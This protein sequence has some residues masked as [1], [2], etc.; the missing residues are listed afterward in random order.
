M[1]LNTFLRFL[2]IIIL[3]LNVLYL[4]TMRRLGV[5]LYVDIVLGCIELFRRFVW[6]IFRLEN[7]Q[8]SNIDQYRVTMD[9]PL[10]FETHTVLV[11]K[12]NHLEKFEEFRFKLCPCWKREDDPFLDYETSIEDFISRTTKKILRRK[13]ENQNNAS[14]RLERIENPESVLLD[15]D[16][17]R[18]SVDLIRHE[19]ELKFDSIGD[20]NQRIPLS[21]VRSV[22]RRPSIVEPQDQVSLPEKKDQ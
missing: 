19:S 5:T 4:D 17:L 12:E 18:H 8:L 21:P 11:E 10:P 3:I 6:N 15:E 14:M 13:P 20:T 9:V 22:S 7:E 1:I 16:D 2:W